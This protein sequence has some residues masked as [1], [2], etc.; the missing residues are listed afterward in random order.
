[1]GLMIAL[2]G[3]FTGVRSSA[4]PPAVSPGAGSKLVVVVV[5]VVDVFLYRR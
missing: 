3:G 4:V 2:T 5:V 1:M